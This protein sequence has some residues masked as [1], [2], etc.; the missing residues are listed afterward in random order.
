MVSDQIEKTNQFDLMYTIKNVFSLNLCTYF[1]L[2]D[3]Y[4]TLTT[5]M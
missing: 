3:F 1:I 5:T 4:I 2:F